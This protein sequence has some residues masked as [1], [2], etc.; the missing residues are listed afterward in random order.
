MQSINRYIYIILKFTT[1]LESRISLTL[2]CLSV[3][4][5]GRF[6]LV[7]GGCL[8]AGQGCQL[9]ECREQSLIGPSLPTTH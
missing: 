6:L 1:P 5:L 3:A 2:L 4:Q 7:N 9:D 8:R